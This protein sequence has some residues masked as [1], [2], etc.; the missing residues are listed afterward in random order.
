VPVSQLHRKIIITTLIIGISLLYYS[1]QFYVVQHT[2]LIN[3]FL[4]LFNV[5]TVLLAFY[6][7]LCGWR[8]VG[9][10]RRKAFE[11]LWQAS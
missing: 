11:F 8:I 4:T 7:G 1:C 9:L 10:I 3:I 2:K 5:L 6:W